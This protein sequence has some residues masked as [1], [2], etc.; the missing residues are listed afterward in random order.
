[1]LVIMRFILILMGVFL[2]NFWGCVPPGARQFLFPREPWHYLER[3]LGGAL[4]D[5]GDLKSLHLAL[6]RSLD[7]LAQKMNGGKP[8]PPSPHLSNQA[9]GRAAL[10]RTLTRFRQILS[11]ADGPVD[12]ERKI[13]ERFTFW[14]AQRRGEDAPVLLTGYYEPVVD[15]NTSP[16]G[17][18]RYPLYRRP[19]DLI[20]V[21][22]GEPLLDG[23]HQKLISRLEEGRRIPYYSRREIDTEGVLEGRGLELFW[24]SDPWERF[25]LHVQGSG[26]VQLPN[27]KRVRVGYAGSNGRSYRSIGRVLVERGFLKE[28]DV[29]L[30]RVR[31]FLRDNPG[32]MDEIFNANERY[33]FFRILPGMKG[34]NGSLGVPLTAGRSVATDPGVYPPGA[35]AYL[36]SRQPVLDENG[37]MIGKKMI[38]RFVF[39]QDTGAAM[40]GP[41]R[42]DLFFGMGSDA[43]MA[44][45]VMK[46]EGRIFLL[47]AR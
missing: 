24:L 3:E 16:G 6:E 28:D 20:E 8:I 25:M 31:E 10:Y 22:T 11:T 39:N 13:R 35:L 32:I 34:P 45:G 47:K 14:E 37:N 41:G 30:P 18:Y 1:M 17:A 43:G 7:Y 27:G 21:K 2:L 29:S 15:G 26:L 23:N 12:L 40:Q 19:P 33:I 42:V 4:R 5:D 9:F 46:E 36:V 44:A 38:Q